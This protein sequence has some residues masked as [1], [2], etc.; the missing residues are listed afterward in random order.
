[1][2]RVPTITDAKRAIASKRLGVGYQKFATMKNLKYIE[3]KVLVKR[4]ESMSDKASKIVGN[5][6]NKIMSY[7]ETALD[8]Q[9][10]NDSQDE[11]LIN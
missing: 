6:T 9:I 1:M 8:S 7:M 5:D 4:I 3:L 11:N 10:L 2:R